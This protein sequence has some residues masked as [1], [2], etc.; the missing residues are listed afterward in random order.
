MQGG[1]RP[2][3]VIKT[4]VI[5]YGLAGSVFHAPIV[6][7][8]EEFDL[9]AIYTK[10]SI[11]SAA[12]RERYHDTAIVSDVGEIFRDESIELVIVASLNAYHYELAEKAILAGKNVIV[13]KPITIRSQDADRL[14]ALAE[15]KN[16]MLSV[17]Q[18][19]RWDGDF[20]TVKKVKES[21]MLGRIVEFESRF[22]KFRNSNKGNWREENAP[23]SGQLYDL[24]PHLIDQALDLFGL[25]SAVT[26]DIRTQRECAKTIDNFELILHYDGL[27]VTLKVGMLVKIPAP[28]F[29][30]IGENGSFVKYGLDVQ[31]DDLASGFTPQNLTNW[32]QEPEAQYGRISAI[33]G[34]V[35]FDGTVI[36]EPGDYREYLKNIHQVLTGGGELIVK[37]QQSANNI[38]IIE[39]AIRS[40]E[41]RRTVDLEGLYK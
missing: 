18:N 27:K 8:L 39:Q 35:D 2:M 5:G 13:D 38:R 20:L 37:P 17:Y 10:D 22:D 12:A 36:S 30:L 9:K 16:V 19:R 31:E 25:P 41:E 29:T 6:S 32:G 24:G 11:R 33:A 14:I 40:S 26:A 3:R 28:R 34:G 21:G 1:K 4:A 23:G 7:C 15:E